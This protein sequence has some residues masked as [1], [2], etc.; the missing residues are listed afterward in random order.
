MFRLYGFAVSNYY[1]VVK[2]AMLEKGL[3]F[4]EVLV[5]PSDDP[6]YLEKS[7]MGKVPC[8]ETEEGVVSESQ[9]MLDYLEDIRPE[10]RLYPV[11][12]FPRAKVRELLRVIE[13]YLE[14][15]AR[16][17]YPEA[18]FG[19]RISDQTRAEVRPALEKGTAAL[20]RLARFEPFLAG[21]DFTCA[22]I[23]AA[24]HLPLAGDAARRIYGGSPLDDL[25]ELAPYL[26]RV[27]ERPSFQ[28]T[29]DD[30]R[31]AL[32]AYLKSRGVGD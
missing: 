27:R 19:G 24:I 8:L 13:L 28:R 31:Q 26:K 17:L 10:P 14:L 21:R 16:R 11:E 20:R 3:E 15:P 7:P 32:E 12:A 18:F 29:L 2:T 9:V 22:D 5:Y 23:G 30:S 4:E 6:G 25:G 1:N